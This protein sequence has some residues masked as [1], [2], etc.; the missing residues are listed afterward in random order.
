MA[1]QKLKTVGGFTMVTIPPAMMAETGLKPKASV[2]VRV[3]DGKI[4]VTPVSP[5]RIGLEARLAM[6]DFTQPMSDEERDWMND[7]PVGNEMI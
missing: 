4:I 3:E 2:D 1:S 6:C 7:P 5:G